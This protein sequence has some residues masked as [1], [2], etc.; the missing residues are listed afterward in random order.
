V[1][2]LKAA[3]ALIIGKANMHELAASATIHVSA[4]AGSI[5]IPSSLCGVTG[6]K[7]THDRLS[8]D[9][10]MPLAPSFG[11][12]IGRQIVEHYQ[13]GHQLPAA[14]RT[15]AR[16][17]AFG[18][19]DSFL[20]AL[21][22][23]DAL[24]LP[25]S[26]YPAPCFT[27]DEIEVGEGQFMNVFSGVNLVHLPGQHR[28]TAVP[29]PARP[30]HPGRSTCRRTARRTPRRGV[31]ATAARVSLPGADHLSPPDS[32]SPDHCS[33]A[34]VKTQPDLSRQLARP[35]HCCVTH[36]PLRPELSRGRPLS[37]GQLPQENRKP[38]RLA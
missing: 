12:P 17:R 3:G 38:S 31:D 30:L 35:G 28:R 5:R 8:M 6:L 13:Y 4:C 7:P 25:W 2:R 10:V 20:T 23:V 21:R 14:R 16:A 15:R 9:G 33:D 29:R 37:C 19:R 34:A 18:I 32:Q 1:T 22:Q 11:C 27:D 24:L 26:P 36:Y